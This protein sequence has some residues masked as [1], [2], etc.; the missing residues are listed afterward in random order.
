VGRTRAG[1]GLAIC[2]RIVTGLGGELSVESEVGRGTVLRT[3][4]PAAKARSLASPPAPEAIVPGRRGHILLVDDEVM[5]GK[6]LQRMLSAEHDVTFV[7]SALD[8]IAKVSAGERF[9]VILCDLMMPDVTGM[10]LHDA[11]LRLAPQQAEKMVFVTGGAFTR[12]AREFLD[13]V[14]N[15][16]VDKPIDAASLKALVRG[17]LR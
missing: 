13:Q 2:H 16:R 11:L 12:R 10:D 7:T 9:D 14:D 1:L 8:A 5:L 15:P 6:V 3:I 4:L 17:L